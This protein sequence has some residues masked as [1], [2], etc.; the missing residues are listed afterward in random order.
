MKINIAGGTGIMG[1]V[2]RPVFEKSG[3]EVTLSGRKTSQSLEEAASEAD[4]TIVSVPIRAT[5]DMIKR[6]APY[7]DA[8]MD[9][10]GVKTFSID[11]MLK[12]S[13]EDCEVGG[14]HPLYG[15]VPSI[16]GRTVV[17]CQTERSGVKCA[18]VLESFRHSGVKV[19]PMDSEIH[20]KAMAI[21]QNLRVK[22]LGTYALVLDRMGLS[23]DELYEI[24]PRPTQVLI[25]LI[26]RQV[27][28]GNDELYSCLLY[29]SPSPR[30]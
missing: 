3:H 15:D 27:E 21:L 28:P 23:V 18:E 5:K 17:Y 26:A 25:D 19:K 1:R 11:A 9:F 10:T 20:D 16:E 30:D 6:V 12:Y 8:L 7:C 14:L 24:S 13:N 22:L 4:L 29:T 2:H